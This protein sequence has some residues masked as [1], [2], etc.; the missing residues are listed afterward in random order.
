MQEGR[1]TVG[2]DGFE[3]PRPF[4]VMATQ[5]PLEMEGTYPLPEAQLDRFFFKLKVPFPEQADLV[6]I[7]RRTTGTEEP[8][9]D[10]SMTGEELIAFQDLLRH[11][12]VADPLAGYAAAL[13]LATH[14]DREGPVADVRRYLA[15]GA[16]PRGMQTLILGARVHT[17][18]DGRTAVS[19]AD[20]RRVARPALRHR[21]LLNFEGE[22]E[23]VDVDGLIDE[24]LARVP[25]PA[26]EAR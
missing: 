2:G 1:V 18:L 6:E 12:P 24:I 26:G 23:A 17:L 21:L 4:F 14:P 15:Y 11:V 8:Q 19:A 16:S 10:V 25:T 13:V 22:A 9:V 7:S 5:N 20:I 3:L